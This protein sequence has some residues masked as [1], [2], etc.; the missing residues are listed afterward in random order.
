M[1]T[2]PQQSDVLI[3]SCDFISNYPLRN[4]I[5]FYRINDSSLSIL[6]ANESSVPS[7]GLVPG[8][9]GKFKAG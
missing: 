1:P 9:K 6:I 2:Y 5:N 8:R 3:L 4:F 7:Q